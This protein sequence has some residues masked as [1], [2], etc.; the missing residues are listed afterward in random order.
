MESTRKEFFW[1][2]LGSLSIKSKEFSYIGTHWVGYY[3]YLKNGSYIY[4]LFCA[5]YI[6]MWKKC[7]KTFYFIYNGGL[8]WARWCGEWLQNPMFR[9]SFFA[10][11]LSLSQFLLRK[12]C[13]Q[14]HC[15]QFLKL[16]NH[17][18]FS[19]ATMNLRKCL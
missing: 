16:Q 18:F 7:A 9:L 4:L 1:G 2:F 19:T 10:F 6:H 12:I 13:P 8:L 5:K 3:I 14:P 15:A 11:V 17:E